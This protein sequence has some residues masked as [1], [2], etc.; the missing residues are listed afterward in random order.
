MFLGTHTPKLDEKGRLI[1]PAKFREPL[2]GGLVMTKGQERCVVIW[3][4]EKFDEYAESL[5]RRSQNNEKVR[6]YTRVFFSSAFDD[7]ADKQ[8]RVTIPAPLREWAGLD[9]DLVV[10]GAD[11]RIEVW[12]TVAWNQYLEVQEPGFAAL[13]ED[14]MP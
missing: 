6:A 5:R 4:N 8:G 10:V 2:V 11:T 3:P 13:D 7:S 14:V 12:A 9:R 1:L